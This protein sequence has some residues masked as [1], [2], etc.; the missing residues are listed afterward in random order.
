MAEP[1]PHA[2]GWSTASAR[3]RRWQASTLQRPAAGH[4][5]LTRRDA[6]NG[7]ADSMQFMLVFGVTVVIVAPLRD[8][9]SAGGRDV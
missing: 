4:P 6:G 2:T 7:R 1:I 8:A 3:S 5:P 9:G